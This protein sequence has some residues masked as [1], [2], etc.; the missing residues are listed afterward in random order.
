MSGYSISYT[1]RHKLLN[2][3]VAP[4]KNESSET[5]RQAESALTFSY[6]LRMP[7]VSHAQRLANKFG[8]LAKAAKTF[9]RQDTELS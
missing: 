5:P 4:V 2:R 8:P 7:H 6:M 3:H 1:G 9:L